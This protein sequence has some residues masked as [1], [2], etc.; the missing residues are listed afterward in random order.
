MGI[1]VRQDDLSSAEVHALIAE[2]LSGM[3]SNS[4]PGRVNALAIQNLRAPSV[5]FWTARV[6]GILC[7]C[8]ALKELDPLTGEVKS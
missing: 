8:G 4:P 3:H 2:H 1:D 7:G 6:D 5:T